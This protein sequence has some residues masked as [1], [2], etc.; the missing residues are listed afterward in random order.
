MNRVKHVLTSSALYSLYCT[1]V[2]P[3]LT[4]CCEVW[5]N[6]YPTRFHSLFILQKRAIR[7]CLYTDYKCHTKPLFYQLTSLN[8]F[9]TTDFNSLVFMYKAFHN[10]LP[11]HLLSYFTKVNDSH[12]HNTRINTLSFK[13]R[14]RRTSKKALCI[15]VKGSKLWNAL[16]SDIKLSRNVNAFKKMLKALLLENY[17]F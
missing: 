3:Y 15:C 11:T 5:G 16:S 6:N 4:Y 13:V 12:N 14:Y 7:I 1:L 2:M 9:D 17:K 8:V 10:L